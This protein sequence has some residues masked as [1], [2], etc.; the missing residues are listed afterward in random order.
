MSVQR[1]LGTVSLLAVMAVCP[2]R[3]RAAGQGLDGSDEAQ[4]ATAGE[5]GGTWTARDSGVPYH[6]TAVT[7]TGALL[8]VPNANSGVILTSPDGVSWTVHNSAAGD[9][10][11]GITWTGSKLVAVGVLGK[12]V[13]S[14]DGVTWTL[15][16]SGVSG[17]LYAVCWTGAQLVAAGFGGAILTS[18]D[19]VTWTARN[20]GTSAYLRGVAWT[21]SQLVV[22]GD[23][24]L[25]LTS[26]DGALWTKRTSG[27]VNSL[28]AV[29]ADGALI[30]AVGTSKW[31]YTSPDGTTWTAHDS[32]G[33]GMTNLYAVSWTG[34]LFATVG[35]GGAIMTSPDGIAWTT[36]AS[37]SS[38]SLMGVVSTGSQLVVV[39]SSGTILT[40]PC[41]TTAYPYSAWVP[42]VSHNGGLNGSQ[43]R[44]D[45]GL[46]NLGTVQANVK[47]QLYSGASPVTTT[48]YV[49]AGAQS[50]VID[51]ADQLGV[52][53]SGALEVLSDQPLKI[54][55]RT[56]NQSSTGT[57]GQDYPSYTSDQGLTAYSRAG[58]T[59]YL[60]H[61]AENAAFRSNIGLTN[62]G[63]TPA[64][65]NVELHNGDG[66]VLATYS[67][68]LDPGEWKQ[69]TQP[70]KNKAHTNTPRAYAKVTVASGSGVIACASLIDNATNDPTTISMVR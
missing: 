26:P 4:A 51:I 15:R 23:N 68:T 29:A 40:S 20:S 38:A 41:G 6:L 12:I 69:E 7:W 45:V 25:I 33:T 56:Y 67:V 9:A 5:C 44:S 63:S 10:L 43:W 48:T 24:G 65:V 57:F 47:F 16:T 14:S 50:V 54:T 21:G 13:T 53:G 1:A 32:G 60:P 31:V 30:V 34:S 37:G 58:A 49:P 46:L 62:T 55:S 27:T 61:L 19:G 18:P 66:G 70:L 52:T 42:V 11:Y 28:T 8:A 64:T 35:S 36:R 22:V 2:A 39:G 59:A 3:G 17:D